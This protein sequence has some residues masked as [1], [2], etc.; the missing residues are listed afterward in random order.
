MKF[1]NIGFNNMV[2]AAR[3]VAVIGPD[4]APAKRLIQDAK[5][6]G[7]AIDCTSGRR[8]RGIIITDSDHVILSS[9]QPETVAARLTGEE[10]EDVHA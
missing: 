5:D 7:R 4:S 6:S 3:V 10:E 8:T 9:I 2:A 1:I